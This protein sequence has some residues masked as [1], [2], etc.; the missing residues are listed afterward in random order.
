VADS[1][2]SSGK[3]EGLLKSVAETIGSTLGTLAAKASAAQKTLESSTN[4][5]IRKVSPAKRKVSR[6]K[7]A[8]RAKRSGSKRSKPTAGRAGKRRS[9]GKKRSTRGKR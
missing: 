7:P 3:D 5:V 2:N 6:K 8:S 4:E 9:G 1:T